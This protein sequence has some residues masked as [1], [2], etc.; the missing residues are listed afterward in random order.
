MR[1]SGGSKSAANDM[2]ELI[3]G[4]STYPVTLV[5]ADA[6]MAEDA[7]GLCGIGAISGVFHAS[8]VLADATVGNQSLSGIR[9]VFAPKV[10]AMDRLMSSLGFHPGAITVLFSSVASLTGSPGQINYSA[11]NSALD[12]LATNSTGRGLAAV[13][14]QGGAGAGGGMAGNDSSTRARAERTGI[15]LVEPVIGLDAMANLVLGLNQASVVTCIPFT[16]ERFIS[17]QYKSSDV[18]VIFSNYAHFKKAG[19]S[20]RNRRRASKK[21]ASRPEK[22]PGAG[23]SEVAILAQVQEAVAAILGKE[24]GANDPLMSAGLDSLS[25][26]EFKNDL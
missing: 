17:N 24:V 10:E 13:T 25:A 8:G 23:V 9:S 18:P 6:S 1:S 19:K 11:A 14:R 5:T 21:V 15:G 26:V 12:M 2:S 3:Q 4:C 22:A 20:A 7:S 16:W